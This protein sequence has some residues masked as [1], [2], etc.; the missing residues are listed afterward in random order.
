[1]EHYTRYISENQKS[2]P[3]KH[4]IRIMTYN[5][6]GFKKYNDV[7]EVLRLSNA[8]IIGLNE[9]L[10]FEDK[11]KHLSELRDRF[12]FDVSQMGYNI[13]MCNNYGINVILSKHEIVYSKIIK[14]CKDPIKNRNRYA[15]HVNISYLTNNENR[16][17]INIILTHL[18]AFDNIISNININGRN[19]N[20]KGATRLKQIIEISKYIG[21]E[22]FILMGDFNSEKYSDVI[23]LIESSF[24]NSF[25]LLN[26]QLPNMTSWTSKVIDFIFIDHRFPYTPIHT[27]VYYSS[28]SDHLPVY[29]DF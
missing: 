21:N 10:F 5:V 27:G 12:I 19:F 9:A 2:F 15:L 16:C 28:A 8:D 26:K 13:K 4:N 1:M 6:E 17:N 18:D 14:L 24:I 29:I 3:D 11:T 25:D 22:N 7:I 20:V 23:N